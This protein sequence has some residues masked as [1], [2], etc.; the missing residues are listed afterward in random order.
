MS[1]Q[2]AWQIPQLGNDQELMEAWQHAFAYT[3][4][5]YPVYGTHGLLSYPP[6][7]QG[8][9]LPVC[10]SSGSASLA[11]W[12]WPLQNI[13]SNYPDITPDASLPQTQPAPEAE[14]FSEEPLT[15]IQELKQV[16][17]GLQHRAEELE[18]RFENL[19]NE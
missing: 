13:P 3:G 17:L 5:Y 2:S 16:V 9:Q 6:Y 14:T 1:R 15:E 10:D 18:E 4:G 11:D 12:E 7:T 8:P 19:Q